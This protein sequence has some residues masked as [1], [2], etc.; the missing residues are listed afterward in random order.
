MKT[1][2]WARGE[3]PECDVFQG[4]KV[5]VHAPTYVGFTHALEDNGYEV[6]L[7]PLKRDEAGIWRMDYDD[8]EEKLRNQKIHA[9]ILCSPH[10]PCGRVWTRPGTGTG[11]GAVSD[12]TM[13]M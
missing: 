4:G 12:P 6:V 7:S 3:R 5:L 1:G 10:N 11:D 2:Y 13:S 8:M 9:A